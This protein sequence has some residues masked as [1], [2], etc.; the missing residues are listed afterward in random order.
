MFQDIYI[1]TFH[2][3]ITFSMHTL[4]SQYIPYITF[5]IHSQY[6]PYITFSTH[7]SMISPSGIHIHPSIFM[8]PNTDGVE[9]HGLHRRGVLMEGILQGSFSVQGPSKQQGDS[10]A[11]I[12]LIPPPPLVCVRLCAYVS[13]NNKI[14]SWVL[15]IVFGHLRKMQNLLILHTRRQ[16]N[17]YG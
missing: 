5:S 13:F 10:S 7:I 9:G 6:I 11:F 16:Q 15:T 14:S 4:H 2:P 12:I 17:L 8:L 3:Y 1:Q